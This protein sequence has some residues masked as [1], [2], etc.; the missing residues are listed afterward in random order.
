MMLRRLRRYRTERSGAATAE[1]A[2]V[3]TLLLLPILNVIDLGIYIY[4]RMELDNAAQVA[5]H[6]IWATCALD[7][8]LPATPNSY[9]KCPTAPTARDTAVQSTTLGTNVTVTSTTEGY[10]CVNTSTNAL[11]AVGSFPNTKPAD[12]SSVG[13]ASDAP[14]DYIFVTASYTYS[15]LLRNLSVTTLLTTPMTRTASLRLG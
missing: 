4:Q 5:A 10:Y 14:G 12:C 15:P 6:A 11:V 2:L 1:F 3:L 7:I 13:S 9:A 8:N